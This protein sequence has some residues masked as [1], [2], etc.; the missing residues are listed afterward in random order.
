INFN[1]FYQTVEKT[2][3]CLPGSAFECPQHSLAEAERVFPKGSGVS[4]SQQTGKSCIC[5]RFPDQLSLLI[6]FARSVFVLRANPICLNF[7]A[8]RIYTYRK[9]F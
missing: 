1:Y 3:F 7:C 9:T 4:R 5:V 8:K 2:Q 6:F